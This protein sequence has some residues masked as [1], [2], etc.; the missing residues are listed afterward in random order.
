MGILW[1][2]AIIPS[3]HFLID[4]PRRGLRIPVLFLTVYINPCLPFKIS[5]ILILNFK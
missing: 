3:S 4:L 1:T 2:A 5:E